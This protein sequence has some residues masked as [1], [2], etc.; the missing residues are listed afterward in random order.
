MKNQMTEKSQVHTFM[1]K[2]ASKDEIK[3]RKKKIKK[4]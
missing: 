1:L 3:M 4:N 2:N